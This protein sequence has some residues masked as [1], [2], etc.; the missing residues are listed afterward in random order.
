MD[1]NHLVYMWGQ[2]NLL[3]AQSGLLPMLTSLSENERPYIK[4]LHSQLGSWVQSVPTWP[5]TALSCLRFGDMTAIIH[6]G[7]LRDSGP[8]PEFAHVLFGRSLTARHALT[9]ADWPWDRD[10]YRQYK[11]PVWSM[12]EDVAL[13]R[14]SA[15]NQLDSLVTAG[16]ADSGW[17]SRLVRMV[18]TT[19]THPHQ[20]F[21]VLGAGMGEEVGLLWGLAEILETRDL[22]PEGWTFS[23]YEETIP[24]RSGPTYVFYAATPPRTETKVDHV[25]ID[26]VKLP[27]LDEKRQH[28]AARL[29]KAYQYPDEYIDAWAAENRPGE[30]LA[31]RV[32][33]LIGDAPGSRLNTWPAQK[34][35]AAQELIAAE[36]RVLDEELAG[37]RRWHAAQLLELDERLAEHRRMIDA[38]IAREDERL[39]QAKDAFIDYETK[40]HEK[41]AQ[42]TERA[43]TRA[44]E[45]R[46]MRSDFE[47]ALRL[48]HAPG[49]GVRLLE[50]LRA[51]PDATPDARERVWSMIAKSNFAL[52]GIL[53]V[54][55]NARRDAYAT[56]VDFCGDG[57]PE[58]LTRMEKAV[59]GTQGAARELG[60]ILAG[61]QEETPDDPK[62]DPTQAGVLTAVAFGFFVLLVLLF[63][64]GGGR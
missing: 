41:V 26:H 24:E 44:D 61:V 25:W 35:P 55:P 22:L 1:V 64:F 21:S 39:Q 8:R 15:T 45:R 37:H 6:R 2:R 38:Q 62:I 13:E 57:D 42:T 30:T 53:A 29:V 31:Q 59:T 47:E 23:T 20:R 36:A 63:A 9:L 34:P 3:S 60:E 46:A 48:V 19:L 16:L 10:F 18:A 17:R 58:L 32:E 52:P 50:V 4:Q 27:F 7:N 14:V 54:N 12:P 5:A 51:F 40:L 43:G 56:I 49:G 28:A 33:R 11:E